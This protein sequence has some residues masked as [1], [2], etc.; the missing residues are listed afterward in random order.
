MKYI[1]GMKFKVK[2]TVK[3]PIKLSEGDILTIR[4]I[5]KARVYCSINK[6]RMMQEIDINNLSNQLESI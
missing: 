3:D 6:S 1:V 2:Q 5:E 4:K